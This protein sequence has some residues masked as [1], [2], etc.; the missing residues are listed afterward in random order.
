MRR[1][2]PLNCSLHHP[3]SRAQAGREL[4]G[5]RRLDCV[6]YPHDRLAARAESPSKRGHARPR[7]QLA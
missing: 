4:N 6:A 5:V 3:A 2:A 1:L 7:V